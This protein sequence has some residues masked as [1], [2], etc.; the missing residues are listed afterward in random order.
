[1]VFLQDHPALLD[2][3]RKVAEAAKRNGKFA[4]TVGNLHNAGA[5]L[6]MG[7]KFI[8]LGADVLGLTAYCNNIINVFHETGEPGASNKKYERKPY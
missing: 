8:N 2:A 5:L 6:D 1:M 7:Y 3:R 4:A